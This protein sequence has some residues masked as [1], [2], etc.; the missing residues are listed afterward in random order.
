MRDRQREIFIDRGD[1]REEREDRDTQSQRKK[2]IEIDIDRDRDGKSEK[3]KLRDTY[4]EKH[5]TTKRTK[6]ESVKN[7]DRQSN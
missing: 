3:K 5:I 6:S 1:K 2:D 4:S 7:R